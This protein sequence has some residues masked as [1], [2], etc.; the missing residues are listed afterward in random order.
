MSIDEQIQGYLARV[1]EGRLPKPACCQLC[2][3]SGQMRWH[4]SY[5]RTLITLAQTHV[6]PIKRVFCVLC[7][8]TFAH[9]PIFVAKFHRYAKELI[10]RALRLLKSR[11]YEAVA[12]WF[13]EEGRRYVAVMTLHFWRRRFA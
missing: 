2:G 7:G 6:L 3:R 13:V 8:G 1:R 9:L 11:T 12:D 4:G 5:L 10:R